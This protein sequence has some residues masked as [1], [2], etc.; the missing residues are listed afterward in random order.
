MGS[1]RKTLED[2]IREGHTKEKA[3]KML[4]KNELERIYSANKKTRMKEIKTQIEQGI[5]VSTEDREQYTKWIKRMQNTARYTRKSYKK[6]MELVESANEKLENGQ[7][8]LPEEKNAFDAYQR[9]LS[10]KR[11][12]RN[13]KA[14]SNT[15]LKN[16]TSYTT[17]IDDAIRYDVSDISDVTQQSNESDE[18]NETLNTNHNPIQPNATKNNDPQDINS[19]QRTHGFS[20]CNTMRFTAVHQ[21]PYSQFFNP[22]IIAGDPSNQAPFI[23]N[24]YYNYPTSLAQN[25]NPSVPSYM[26]LNMAEKMNTPFKQRSSTYHSTADIANNQDENNYNQPIDLTIKKQQAPTTSSNSDTKITS[27]NIVRPIPR[28]PNPLITVN[29]TNINQQNTND[30]PARQDHNL[31][32][33]PTSQPITNQT[34]TIN[35]SEEQFPT[36]TNKT[37]TA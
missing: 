3:L 18:Q 16:N 12:W 26:M 13:T 20:T 8:I 1:K 19:E 23:Q 6:M 37:K 9:R 11:A 36:L 14:Q 25:N 2:L 22:Q 30:R 31:N 29:A 7:D 28:Y 15:N 27:T 35:S 34:I 32:T 10:Y 33:A 5:T 24:N 17:V 21:T 4:K